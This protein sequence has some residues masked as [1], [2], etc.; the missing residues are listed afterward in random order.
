MSGEHALFTAALGLT[1]P[2]QVRDLTFDAEVGRIDFQVGFAPGSRFACPSCGAAD[3]PVHDTRQRTWQHLHFFEHRAYIHADVPRVRCEHCG[4]TS[5]VAV[6]WA[7][8]GSGFSQLLEAMV[9]ALAQ[10]MP[11]RA[12]ARHVGLG[13]DAVWRTL[14]H[15]VDTA[16][17]AEDYS[18]VTAIG[19]DETAARRGHHYITLFHDLETGRLL[20]ACPG[21][22]QQTVGHFVADLRAHGGAPEQVTAA[23]TD[24]SRAY[25]AGLGRHLPQ[26]AI[27]FD[28]FHVVQLA[29]T[30]VDEVRRQEVKREPALKHTRWAWLQDPRQQKLGRITQLHHL[31]RRRLETARAWRLKE[32]LRDFY[33]SQ[34]GRKEAESLLTA[35]YRWARRSR[36]APFK[37]LALTVRAH[38]DGILNAFDSRLT[39]GRVEGLNAHIQAAKARARGYR[40][41]RNLITM[42]YL[43]GAKLSQLPAAPHTPTS[44]ARAA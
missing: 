17:A 9:V 32:A 39:N 27:T 24:M 18:D 35:W 33:R 15:Y 8:P 20:F 10:Q 25:I 7:R 4:R 31:S 23:C 16:R 38:W 19:V 21:R 14:H 42:A 22:D 44:G 1:A 37:R 28:A 11:V 29:N 13:D 41:T 6:P 30:A 34:S 2:W 26:A 36:L 12:V 40:T 43:V 3:Q 5:Q